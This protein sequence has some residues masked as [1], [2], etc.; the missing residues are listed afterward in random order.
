[1]KAFASAI[2]CILASTVAAAPQSSPAVYLLLA[3]DQKSCATAVAIS[4]HELLTNAHVTEGLCP[5]GRCTDVTVQRSAF[6]GAVPVPVGK[7]T[8][9]KLA[10]LLGG[11]DIAKLQF[12]EE[13]EFQPLVAD[14]STDIGTK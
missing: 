13:F 8:T 14:L 11:L 10:R 1:M 4:A 12:E 2:L 6:E 5:F 9:P 7:A 3:A